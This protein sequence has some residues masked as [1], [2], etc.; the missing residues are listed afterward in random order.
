MAPSDTPLQRRGR[1]PSTRAQ[2]AIRAAA[3]VLFAEK[4]YANTSVRDIATRAS[5]DPGLIARH[6][7]S[8]DALFIETMGMDERIRGITEGPR[9]QLGRN[10]LRRLMETEPDHYAALYKALDRSDVRDYLI[11]STEEHVIQP[12]VARLAGSNREL[13]ARLVAAQISGLIIALR[14]IRR[15]DLDTTPLNLIYDQYAPA[16]Q[17][18]IDNSFDEGRDGDGEH[19]D[20]Q[21][22]HQPYLP[23]HQLF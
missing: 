16:I 8:K 7:G 5:V 3:T 21:D 12:L 20:L 1:P 19:A 23:E 17:A 15:P 6:F 18:L 9:D 4:G 14:V 10:I 13:R 2:D 22:R 11:A